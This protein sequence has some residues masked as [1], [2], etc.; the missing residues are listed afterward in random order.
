MCDLALAVLIWASEHNIDGHYIQPGKPQQNGHTKGLNDK[1]R[2]ECL[3]EHWFCSITEA[4]QIVKGT[5]GRTTITSS[6]TARLVT[7]L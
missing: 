2:D 5:G 7:R 4:R 1:I 6:R 3:N